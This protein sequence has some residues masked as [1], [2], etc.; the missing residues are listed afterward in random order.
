[1]LER[2]GG[3]LKSETR[4]LEGVVREDIV[5]EELLMADLERID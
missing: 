2:D 1:M 3:R 5:G 4:D